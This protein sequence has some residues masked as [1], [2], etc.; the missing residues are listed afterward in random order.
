MFG[1]GP[2]LGDRVAG[3]GL[4]ADERRAR[5]EAEHQ[6][7]IRTISRDQRRQ[8]AIDRTV[9]HRKNVPD[10]LDIVE[11]GTAQ[12][13]QPLDQLFGGVVWR[14]GKRPEARDEDAR[15]AAHH[16]SSSAATESAAMAGVMRP[17]ATAASSCFT[18]V[19]IAGSDRSR[20][21]RRPSSIVHIHLTCCS[22][23]R[24]SKS[25]D[26]FIAVR[27]ARI[28]SHSASMPAPVSAE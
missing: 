17:L 8:F 27:C 5:G 7:R 16:F 12:A 13:Q 22:R 20:A 2:D 14:A 6:Q 21:F 4:D 9:G 23:R 11:R 24:A 26:A 28:F 19:R 3:A 25:P 15:P 1:I 18:L 10:T